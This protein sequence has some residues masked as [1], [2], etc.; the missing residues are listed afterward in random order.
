MPHAKHPHAVF[1]VGGKR[2]H[3]NM[4]LSVHMSIHAS[5]K[6][7]TI[8]RDHA[9][10]ETKPN[11]RKSQRE[12]EISN[13]SLSRTSRMLRISKRPRMRTPPQQWSDDVKFQDP[14]EACRWKRR[15]R[16][17]SSSLTSMTTSRTTTR[18]TT[19]FAFRPSIVLRD[20]VEAPCRCFDDSGLT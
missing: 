6:D 15:G 2:H 11:Q 17:L 19:R 4:S 20:S 18:L 10:M 13:T 8:F 12:Q 9:G 3:D 1:G 14:I 16:R 7:R 5:D